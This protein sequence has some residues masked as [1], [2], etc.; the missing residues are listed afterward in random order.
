MPTLPITS[1]TAP[2]NTPDLTKTIS[3][4]KSAKIWPYHLPAFLRPQDGTTYALKFGG[5][6]DIGETGGP[7]KRVGIVQAIL[8]GIPDH[9]A[10][11]EA[12]TER[13]VLAKVWYG[14]KEQEGEAVVVAKKM[15]EE[16]A[17][18]VEMKK[19]KEGEF[20]VVVEEVEVEALGAEKKGDTVQ[21]GKA[22]GGNGFEVLVK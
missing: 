2:H 21:E 22:L 19:G 7:T 12:G 4:I 20:V 14:V 13:G 17:V 11:K 8:Y 9:G 10:E 18:T 6:A 1:T 16:E 15:G 5:A 3:V